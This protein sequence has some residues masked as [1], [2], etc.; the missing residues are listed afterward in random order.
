MVI[1]FICARYPHYFSLN[2]S[3]TTLTN[4][5]LG[6]ET[7]LKET[8]PLQVL[9]DNVPEDFAI[10]LRD[11]MT[12]EYRFKAGV[13]CTSQGWSLGTKIDMNLRTMHGPVPDYPKQMARSMDKYVAF[14][15]IQS[16]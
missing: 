10:V 6:T 8:E 7:R 2:D 5:I 12:G 9:L 1:Q 13:V 3:K 16:C 15:W 11:P 14:N 4:R